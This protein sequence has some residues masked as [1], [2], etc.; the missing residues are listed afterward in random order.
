MLLHATLL[1]L[2]G[3]LL[4]LRLRAL[5]LLPASVAA[6]A[7]ASLTGDLVS[8]SP[9]G[10]VMAIVATLVVLQIGYL[11]GAATAASKGRQAQRGF[12]S[13]TSHIWY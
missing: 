10:V 13:P 3:A 6:L 7:L 11:A 5:V 1:F 4:G 9:W 12:R 8:D 2:T